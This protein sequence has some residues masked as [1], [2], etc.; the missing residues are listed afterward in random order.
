MLGLKRSPAEQAPEDRIFETYFDRLT[1]F[2]VTKSRVLQIE[3]VSQDPELAAR[4]ANTIAS[5]Y[6]NVQSK[7]KRESARVTSWG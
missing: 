4:G 3:F 6:I 1:V 2:N 7:A 5:L